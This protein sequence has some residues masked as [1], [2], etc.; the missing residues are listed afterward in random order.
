MSCKKPI[1]IGIDGIARK[2]VED[3]SMSGV[4]LDQENI[5]KAIDTIIKLKNETDSLSQMGENGYNFVINNFERK[6]L[7]DKYLKYML[8]LSNK[9]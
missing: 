5:N 2:V 3:D 7:S 6:S 8:K 4:Y 9:E 1:L